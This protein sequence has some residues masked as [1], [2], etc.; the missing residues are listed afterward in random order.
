MM[1]SNRASR[2]MCELVSVVLSKYP[3]LESPKQALSKQYSVWLSAMLGS[4]LMVSLIFSIDLRRLWLMN[5]CV[6]TGEPNKVMPGSDT[7]LVPESKGSGSAVAA[8]SGSGD[9]T[10]VFP[11]HL[12]QRRKTPPRP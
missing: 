6:P 10:W 11:F 4:W 9:Q 1:E 2:F 8:N 3:I 7:F 5:S 12:L